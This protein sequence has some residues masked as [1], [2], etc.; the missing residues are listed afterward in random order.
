MLHLLWMFI[1]GIVVGAIARFIMPGAEHIGLLMT[2][3]LGIAGSFVGGFIARIFNKPA[4]GAIVHPAGLVMS[5]IG[6]V[7]LLFVWNHLGR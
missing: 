2:G 1:V 7:I 6:A 3:V 5:V 4:D